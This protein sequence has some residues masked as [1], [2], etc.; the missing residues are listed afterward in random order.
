MS[1]KEVLRLHLQWVHQEE[2]ISHPVEVE[3]YLHQAVLFLE[4]INFINELKV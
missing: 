4:E 2:G 1:Q 3:C